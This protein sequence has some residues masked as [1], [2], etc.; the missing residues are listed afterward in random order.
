M[1]ADTVLG[2]STISGVTP[3]YDAAPLGALVV[4]AQGQALVIPGAST[5]PLPAASTHDSSGVEWLPGWP[6]HISVASCAHPFSPGTDGIATGDA[7]FLP[8]SQDISEYLWSFGLPI[9]GQRTA[10]P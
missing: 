6:C 9:T 7:R 4:Y 1:L 2:F 8:I 5:L 3:I 10:L